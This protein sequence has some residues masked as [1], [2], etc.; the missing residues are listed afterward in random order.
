MND[1]IRKTAREVVDLLRRG[2]V[3]P[4]ELVKTLEEHVTEVDS[5]VNALP[6]R[7]FD[8]AR[9]QAEAMMKRH[10][11]PKD[12]GLLAG[13]PVAVKDYNDVA[14]QRTTF[15]SPIFADTVAD[16][17]D[18]MVRVLEGNGAIAYAKSNV[19]EFAGGHT[20]NPLFGPSR[21]PWNLDRSVG[22]S[23]GGAAACLASGSAWLAT[24]N[25]LG[26]SLR[27]PAGFNGIVGV[28]PTAGRVPRRTPAVP[29]DT[30]WVE[31]PMARNV[32]DAA[33]ML[34]AMIG[35]DDHDPLTRRERPTSFVA[36]LDAY[37]APARVAYSADLGVLP[38][39]QTVRRVTRDSLAHFTAM[40]AEVVDAEPDFGDA[41]EAFQILRAHLIATMHASTLERHRDL[42]KADIVWN[43]EKGLAQS[44]AD[45]QWAERARGALIH[46]VMDFFDDHDVLVVPS[47][48]LP[49]FP[50]EWPAPQEIDGTELTTYIDWIAITFC[51]SLTGCPVVALPSGLDQDGLPIGVQ[52]VGRPGSEARLLSY[53]QRFE[54]GVE[55]A[56]RLPVGRRV[57][58]G[59]VR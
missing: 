54:Q 18:A 39:D 13:L 48:P 47:A 17:S 32:A 46:H 30:L 3:S 49:P 53:A 52:L 16:E 4:L 35:Y 34:D 58:A 1:I 44:T 40:G 23:S 57:A 21:N 19:P 29:F 27:T 43:I 12:R 45:V 15:G 25:D 28:R 41:Y 51:I 55:I 38:V 56:S 59:A 50:V 9:T 6:I 42:I 7:F 11:D 31:G 37:D 10:P 22:G 8:Q 2:E 14:G 5:E 33:L 24:G 36:S 26:G 20:Y